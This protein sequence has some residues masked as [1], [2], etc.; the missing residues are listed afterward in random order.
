MVYMVYETAEIGK[1]KKIY[2]TYVAQH[3]LKDSDNFPDLFQEN[4]FRL[5]LSF[6]QWRIQG[7]K[8]KDGE[9]G[10]RQREW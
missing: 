9:A 1:K 10:K 8:D 5:S 7:A 6:H 2:S 3:P 4:F